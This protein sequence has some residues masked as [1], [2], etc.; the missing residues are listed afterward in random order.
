MNFFEKY[1]FF[2]TSY[3]PFNRCVQTVAADRQVLLLKQ[4]TGIVSGH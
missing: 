1:S 2:H 3:Y 4:L